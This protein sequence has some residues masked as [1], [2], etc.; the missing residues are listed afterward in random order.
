MANCTAITGK[1]SSWWRH[2][3]ADLKIKPLVDAMNATGVIQ[4]VASCEG[5]ATGCR[6]PYVYFRAQVDVAARLERK[7]RDIEYAGAGPLH[8]Y[9]VVESLF[10]QDFDL[11]FTLHPPRFKR[12]HDAA[13]RSFWYLWLHRSQLDADLLTLADIVQDVLKVG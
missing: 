5:H 7:L 10:N 2:A 1:D 8:D 4:T 6:H 13:L 9:W 12:V 3:S 11:V